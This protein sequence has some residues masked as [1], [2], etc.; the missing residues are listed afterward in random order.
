MM[1]S[2]APQ[3][4]PAQTAIAKLGPTTRLPGVYVPTLLPTTSVTHRDYS[5]HYSFF[6]D[7]RS[8][9]QSTT[10]DTL[11]MELGLQN[12]CHLGFEIQG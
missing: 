9:D 12:S 5:N 6:A 1:P 11:Y 8:D 3:R 10:D 4:I 7:R 2:V